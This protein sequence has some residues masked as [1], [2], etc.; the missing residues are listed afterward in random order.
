M[1]EKK[2]LYITYDGLTDPLGQSQILPYLVGLSKEG[3]RFTIL[4]FEKKERFGSNKDIINAIVVQA[5]I[6]WVPLSFTKNPP[7]LSKFYDTLQMK[8]RAFS[9]QRKES[10][11]MVHCRSYIA[12]DIGVKLKKRFGVKFFFD[13]RGFWADEKRDGGAWKDDHPIFKRVYKYYKKR[14]AEYLQNADYIISLTN[15]GKTEMQTW[16]SFD[17]AIPVAVIPCCADMDHFTVTDAGQRTEAKK[18]L[19]IADD[20][21]VISYLGSVGSWYMLDEMLKLFTCI[22]KKHT[23]AFLLFISHSDKDHILRQAKEQGIDDND[24]K[25]VE[26][27]RQEVPVFVK[28]SDINI[29]FIRPVYS[30]LSSSPTKLGEVLSMGIPVIVNAGVGDTEEIINTTG[31]GIVLNDSTEES[32]C[33]ARAEIPNLLKL[34]PEDIRRKAA[35]IFDLEIGIK[36]YQQA[37]KQVFQHTTSVNE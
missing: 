4:S 27:N 10:F 8:I 37:Y 22:R 5:G 36:L 23:N 31:G 28:A 14:E 2:I 15:A 3:Y 6:K 25:I 29:S 7:V 16:K 35:N 17:P 24:I 33:K 30:K 1:P 11:D 18:K 9:L 20:R 12:T 19:G 26:A 32:F 13:M 21:L 34:D